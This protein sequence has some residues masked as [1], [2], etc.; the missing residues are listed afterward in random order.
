MVGVVM[1]INRDK[2]DRLASFTLHRNE[3]VVIFVYPYGK[4]GKSG[5]YKYEWTY[6]AY[7]SDDGYKAYKR[8]FRHGIEDSTV[9]SSLK[10]MLADVKE[11]AV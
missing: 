4:S 7:E 6:T 2:T 5:N 9:F 1:D 11:A 8:E 10:E 3:A